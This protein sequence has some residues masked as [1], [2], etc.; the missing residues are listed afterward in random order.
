MNL[1]MKGSKYHPLKVGW[2]NK[3]GRRRS[4]VNPEW[5]L[6][7]GGT[8]VSL[9]WSRP[10]L[11]VH[12]IVLFQTRRTHTQNR[13]L[14]LSYVTVQYRYPYI[15]NSLYTTKCLLSLWYA[16][17]THANKNIAAIVNHTRFLIPIIRDASRFVSRYQVP[18]TVR[19]MADMPN[20]S[21]TGFKYTC[22]H[23]GK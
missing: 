7:V 19:Y 2:S 10:F 3:N 5:I 12:L 11:H 23:C 16:L 21:C 4:Q 22:N 6:Y 15:K 14:M 9:S 13:L 1:R 17:H 8:V 18:G 20:L